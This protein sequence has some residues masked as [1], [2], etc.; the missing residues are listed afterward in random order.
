MSRPGLG[1]IPHW[2]PQNEQYEL[3]TPI[4]ARARSVTARTLG[5]ARP[6]SWK[7]WLYF[8]QGEEPACTA[9]SMATL[10]SADPVHQANTWMRH[11]DIMQWY[12]DNVA[13]DVARGRVYPGGGATTLATVA[14]AKAR[15]Y[16]SRYEWALNFDT[17]RTWVHTTA[18]LIMGTNWY[19]SMFIRDKEGI[20]RIT[21]TARNE[22]GHDWCLGAYDP[23][24]ALYTYRSTWADGDYLIPEEDL[25]R[26]FRED[27][28][29][30]FPYEV[31]VA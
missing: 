25:A 31:K 19:S 22:G 14:V 3:K 20:A 16:I 15:G 29:A 27:G 6:R 5:L 26:L 9:Y 28:E 10:L 8:D 24:R 23:K 4:G 30:V 2:D 21:K 13:F 7:Q 17:I 1:R 11:L 18:P 12:R